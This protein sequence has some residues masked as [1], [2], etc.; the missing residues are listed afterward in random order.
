VNQREIPL[1]PQ[2]PIYDKEE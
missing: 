1:K 2:K